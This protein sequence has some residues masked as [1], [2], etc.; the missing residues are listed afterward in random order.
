MNCLHLSAASPPLQP[1]LPV[2]TTKQR[3]KNLTERKDGADEKIS[4]KTGKRSAFEEE[5]IEDKLKGSGRDETCVGLGLFLRLARDDQKSEVQEGE[6][7]AKDLLKKLVEDA[8]KL[9]EMKSERVARRRVWK[10]LQRGVD[11]A[12]KKLE[13]DGMMK[14]Q[15]KRTIRGSVKVAHRQSERL[16]SATKT[17]SKATRK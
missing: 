10:S 16:T 8:K 11:D 9:S 4:K 15:N 13:K 3:K 12:K 2:G 1:Y 5:L 6:M 14:K 7:D 17:N